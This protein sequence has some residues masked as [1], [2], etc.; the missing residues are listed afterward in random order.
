MKQERLTYICARWGKVPLEYLKASKRR[1]AVFAAISY[2]CRGQDDGECWASNETLSKES[3]VEERQLR[4]EK[5]AMIADGWLVISRT[6]GQRDVIRCVY[7]LDTVVTEKPIAQGGSN[8]PPRP[9][10]NRPPRGGSNRPP[11]I[12]ETTTETKNIGWAGLK[13]RISPES[14]SVLVASYEGLTPYGVHLFKRGTPE[15]LLKMA[16]TYLRRVECA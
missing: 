1:L 13:K 9:G 5:K 15:V 8:R 16:N 4:R 14:F 3:G 2:H 12:R 7:P 6:M 11:H 10:S